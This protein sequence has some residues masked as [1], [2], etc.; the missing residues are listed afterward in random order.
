MTDFTPE[1]QNLSKEDQTIVRMWFAMQLQI[2]WCGYIDMTPSFRERHE[3]D[4]DCAHVWRDITYGAEPDCIGP[5]EG[6][7]Y[8]L[9]P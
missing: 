8:R 2:Q 1:F 6:V 5:F 3:H 9:K 7:A 4:K